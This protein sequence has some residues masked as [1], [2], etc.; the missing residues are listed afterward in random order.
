MCGP[1]IQ[2]WGTCHIWREL[3]CC[4]AQSGKYITGQSDKTSDNL[5]FLIDKLW[6]GNRQN[7]ISISRVVTTLCCKTQWRD[8]EG[9]IKGRSGTDA[10]WKL[11]GS[12]LLVLSSV[13]SGQTIAHN[14]HFQSATSTTRSMISFQVVNK[15]DLTIQSL[16]FIKNWNWFAYK[17]L[18]SF[19]HLSAECKCKYV[20][21]NLY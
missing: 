18:F 15:R 7:A 1:P 8:N 13:S 6:L 17:S 10:C 21:Q 16:W 9:A 2:F 20:L 4:G 11:R 14:T 5:S 12:P 3:G 19:N